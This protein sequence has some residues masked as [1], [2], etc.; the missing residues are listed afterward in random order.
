M[1]LALEGHGVILTAQKALAFY[2]VTVVL[3]LAAAAI[4][5][6]AGERFPLLNMFTIGVAAAKKK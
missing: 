6:S 4:V 5:R 2:L 3:S 1:M